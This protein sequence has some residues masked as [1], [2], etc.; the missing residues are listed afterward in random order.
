VVDLDQRVQ[1]QDAR[2]LERRAPGGPQQ[3]VGKVASFSW[4]K[5]VEE[6]QDRVDPGFLVRLS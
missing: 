2:L 5:R 1:E 4:C 3:R 6:D